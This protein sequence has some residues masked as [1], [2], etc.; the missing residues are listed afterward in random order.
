MEPGAEPSLCRRGR[1]YNT[2]PLYQNV[3][4]EE[5]ASWTWQLKHSITTLAELSQVLRLTNAERDGL[6]AAREHFRMAI[7]PYLASL[8]DPHDAAC[9]I[10]MQFVPTQQETRSTGEE[11]P[12]AEEQYRVAPGL[13]HRYPD[14]VLLL[15]N[16]MCASYCR[17]CTRKRLTAQANEVLP[18]AEFDQ[19][20]T[21]LR[22]HPEVRDVLI[23]GGDPLTMSDANLDYVLERVR[24]VPSVEIVRLGTRMPMFLPQ[25]ITDDLVKVLAKHHPLWINTHF[26]HPKELTPEARAACQKIVSAGI[27]LG[28][29]SVLLRGVNSDPVVMKELVHELVRARVRPYYLYQCDLVA[30][31]EHFRTP[32]GVG[33]AVMEQLRGHTSGF[34]VPTFVIDA[35]GGG[36]KIP[37]APTYV[38]NVGSRLV[39]LRNYEGHPYTYE[40]PEEGTDCRCSYTDQW[41]RGT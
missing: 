8:M 31:T 6:L 11:D 7:T 20:L 5:W 4:E 15:V 26:N 23:S 38:T 18:H 40:Q 29:Q 17:F 12:L 41:R 37:V 33:L 36:G 22:A 39:E 10:R 1:H 30:G 27:P 24:S 21:Y 32:V 19:A 25:R 34:A 28:N 3:T 14:R 13:I 35:P 16:N 9:P 2:I